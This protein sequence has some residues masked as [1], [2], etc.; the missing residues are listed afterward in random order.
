M[1]AVKTSKETTGEG[2]DEMLREGSF[3][4]AVSVLHH[5]CATWQLVLF[6][7]VATILI[8]TYTFYL[9]CIVRTFSLA[10]VMAQVSGH[11]NLVSL[12]GVVTSGA[13]LLLLI[14]LCEEGSLLALLKAKRIK[15][16]PDWKPF[17]VEDRIKMAIETAKGMAHLT[18]SK[19]VHRDLACRNVLVDATMTCKVA[20]F[21][22]ARGI[23]GARAGP[24]ATEDGDEEEY[25]R[26]RTG[27]FPVR[28]TS[29][30]AMQTMRFSEATDVWS[31]GIVMIE[32]FTDGGKPYAGMANAAVITKVQGGYRAEQPKLCTDQMYAIMLEC[33]AAKAT[34]RPT[35]AK[36]VAELEGIKSSVA[37]ISPRVSATL[38]ASSPRQAVAVND[39]Y[40]TDEPAAPAADQYLTVDNTESLDSNAADDEYLSVATGVTSSAADNNNI[41]EEFEC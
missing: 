36:L 24:A 19:F 35:F 30:E 7:R 31:F 21:G 18:A 33:W 32:L 38:A 17:S 23:A 16:A 6:S 10:T 15:N 37:S 40:M 29:P 1:V 41:S 12:I 20:D 34:N 28:W 9:W 8:L 4:S 27:T 2:A 25:Y 5:P 13:P 22:L 11:P 14:S 26:S 3:H 39:T